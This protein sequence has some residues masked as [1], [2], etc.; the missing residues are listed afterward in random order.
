MV[1]QII[2]E[3]QISPEYLEFE[4]TESMMM[5]VKTVLPILWD[6]KQL[7]VRISLDD[8]GTGYSS[9]YYLKEFPIDIIKID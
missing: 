5:D 2:E 3:T 4:I 7:G 9:L 6:L 8:F 1:H